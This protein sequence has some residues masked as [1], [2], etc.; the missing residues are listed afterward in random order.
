MAQQTEN[1]LRAFAG[2]LDLRMGY[3]YSHQQVITFLASVQANPRTFGASQA[4]VA[5]VQ[6][7][8]VAIAQ[9]RAPNGDYYF[10]VSL[11]PRQYVQRLLHPNWPRPYIAKFKLRKS[12][13]KGVEFW[14]TDMSGLYPYHH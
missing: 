1:I 13:F 14:E 3:Q 4:D 11:R 10:D 12:L 8:C 6:A 5:D 7:I 9:L 2:Q